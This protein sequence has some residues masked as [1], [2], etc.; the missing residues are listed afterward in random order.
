MPPGALDVICDGQVV[1]RNRSHPS[2][3]IAWISHD[4][5]PFSKGTVVDPELK[6]WLSLDDNHHYIPCNTF[7]FRAKKAQHDYRERVPPGIVN[8]ILKFTEQCK[9]AVDGIHARPNQYG[10]FDVDGPCW[11]DYWQ[12]RFSMLSFGDIGCIWVLHSWSWEGR[13]PILIFGKTPLELREI[14]LELRVWLR[15]AGKGADVLKRCLVN[16]LKGEE[17]QDAEVQDAEVQDAEVQGAEVQ[18]AVVV[19]H[20]DVPAT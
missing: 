16:R 10:L 7:L 13:E 9:T 15:L 14:K 2:N 4:D 6:P 20:S 5:H 8:S 19:S 12:G 18:D 1:F 17:V 11:Y 3:G